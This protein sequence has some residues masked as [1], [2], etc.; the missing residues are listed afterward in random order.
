M[1]ANRKYNLLV[2]LSILLLT[3]L[4][5]ACGS[6]S[7]AQPQ[8][9]SKTAEADTSETL[10]EESHQENGNEITLTA[11][12]VA[13][14]VAVVVSVFTARRITTPIRSMMSASQNIAAGQFDQRV[15]IPSHDEL[16]ELGKSFNQMAEEL[17]QT[18][19][20]RMALIGDVAHEL[21]TPLTNIRSIMEGLIDNVLPAEPTTYASVQREVIR[22]QR[23]VQDLQELSRAE[24]GDMNFNVGTISPKVLVNT[25]CERLRL[26]FADKKV[27][28]LVDVPE[29]TPLVRADPARASQILLN[30]LGNALQYT[31][32]GGEVTVR[33]GC[34][35][36]E[37]LFTVADTGIGISPADAPQLFE[38][39]YRVDKSRARATGGSG[40]GLTI[41]KHLVDRQGGRLWVTSEG[42]GHGSEFGF[43]LPVAD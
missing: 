30:L 41:A 11:A 24:A 1:R 9:E 18:E 19:K 32:S 43:T 34:N 36:P 42:I 40:I 3:S 20:R 14:L 17:E 6:S 8:L 13:L 21:R 5:V 12:L 22:L 26:Q 2:L 4:L 28:L 33:A 25:V 29:E 7:E 15:N 35:G 31:E 38:R 16:G 39:F 37:V 10:S 23:L 27:G